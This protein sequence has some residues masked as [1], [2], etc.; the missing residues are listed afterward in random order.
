[1][2]V[3]MN[4]NLLRVDEADKQKKRQIGMSDMRLVTWV[5]GSVGGTCLSTLFVRTYLLPACI[6]FVIS[7]THTCVH[8]VFMHAYACTTPCWTKVYVDGSHQQLRA[9]GYHNVA[10]DAIT[11][12]RLS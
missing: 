5:S 6:Y 8:I 4:I 10:P 12:P 11:V 7:C 9:C 3:K 2:R 1:M